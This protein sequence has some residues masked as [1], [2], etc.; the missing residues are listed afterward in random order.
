MSPKRYLSKERCKSLENI[1]DSSKKQK[2]NSVLK[3]KRRV[4]KLVKNLHEFQ[5]SKEMKIRQKRQD[6]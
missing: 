1:N 4:N 2:K 5:K 6:F 3:T